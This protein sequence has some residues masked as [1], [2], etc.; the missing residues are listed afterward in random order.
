MDE[1]ICFILLL[2]KFFSASLGVTN[3]FYFLFTSTFGKFDDL[4]KLRLLE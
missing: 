2:F 3:I 1:I 4:D